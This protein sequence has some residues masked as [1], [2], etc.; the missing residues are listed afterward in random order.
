MKAKRD[1]FHDKGEF[2]YNDSLTWMKPQEKIKRGW[3][4]LGIS[5]RKLFPNDF[6][7]LPLLGKKEKQVLEDALRV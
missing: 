6:N 4:S 1:C 3:K 7:F 2:Y 5:S